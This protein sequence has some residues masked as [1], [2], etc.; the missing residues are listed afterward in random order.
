E[1]STEIMHLLIAREAVDEHLKVAGDL[2]LGDSRL[3]DKAKPAAKAGAF[4]A[5][6]CPPLTVGAG[7]RPGSFS[8]FGELAKHVRY[9]ERH[10]RKLARSTFYAMGRYHARLVQKGHRA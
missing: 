6:W 7:Q 3:A 5:K 2:V 1:G 9:V 8:E 10:S 4:Y